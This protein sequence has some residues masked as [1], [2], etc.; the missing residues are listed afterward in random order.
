MINHWW[1]SRPKRKLNSV[2]EVLATVANV[3]LDQ[4]WQGQI[5]TH[6]SMESALEQAGLK[7]VG[8]RRDQRGGGAR[9]YIAWLKSLGLLFTQEATG[10]MKLTLAGEAILN[11]EAPVA[12]LT[13]QV[14]KYQFPSNFSIGR[15]VDVSRRFKIHPFWF[16][17]KLLCDERLGQY[18]TQEEIA[19]I[20]IVEAENETDACYN[21]VVNK[22]LAFRNNG[23]SCL[24]NDFSEKYSSSRSESSGNNDIF[25]RLMDVSNTIINWLEYTQYIYREF[26]MITILQEKQE[27]VKRIV[28]NHLNF[29]DRPES[30]EY[31]QRKYGID[32]KHNKDT[33]NLTANR[34]ITAEIIAEMRIRNAFIAYSINTPIFSITNN[35]IEAI[36]Q[37][38][39]FTE[40]VVEDVLLKLFPRGAINAFM[41]NYFEM[42]FK[43]REDATEFEKA[44]KEIFEKVFGYEARHV[45]PIGLT[46]DVHIISNDACYQGIIDNKA[47]LSYTINNDHHNRMVRNYIGEL[48][49]YSD[50]LF[51]LAFFTYIAGGFGRNIDGQLDR[52]RAETGISGSAITVSNVI[53]MVELHQ[54]QPYTH[55][56]IKDILSVGRLVSITDLQ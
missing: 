7:R 35:V 39:G 36:S 6:L 38:S 1:V 34:S 30:E 44:T 42:A 10:L 50:C 49:R 43:G 19:K 11:G 18:I 13:N 48:S 25:S 24:D 33:R 46:P 21:A 12:I 31:Y 51:P 22:I 37:T 56:K 23:N 2:P 45:G 26:G 41:T 17:L 8:D 5:E 16:L 3:S 52:V 47:Y 53:K 40:R 14:L 20:V 9:T 54:Q 32:P 29:I 28:S 27:E 4:E 55:N 15:G